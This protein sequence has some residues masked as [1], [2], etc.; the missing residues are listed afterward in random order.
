MDV[1]KEELK[2]LDIQHY[3]EDFQCSIDYS[4]NLLIYTP[5]FLIALIVYPINPFLAAL[6]TFLTTLCMVLEFKGVEIISTF[7]PKKDCLNSLYIYNPKP[8]QSL[9]I[10]LITA[11]KE[12]LEPFFNFTSVTGFRKKSKIII[13]SILAFNCV[14]FWGAFKSSAMNTVEVIYFWIALPLLVILYLALLAIYFKYRFSKINKFSS[15]YESLTATETFSELIS[16]GDIKNIQLWFLAREGDNGYDEGLD[17]FLQSCP[18]IEIAINFQSLMGEPIKVITEEG[19]LSTA[20]TYKPLILEAYNIHRIIFGTE[21]INGRYNG[22][23]GGYKLYQYGGIKTIT[24]SGKDVSFFKNK[25]L[26][27]LAIDNYKV[28]T[29]Q[30]IKNLDK[31]YKNL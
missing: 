31:F 17:L 9:P 26:D 3:E 13:F 29:R 28:F 15:G 1:I 8:Q 18:E 5:I 23:T 25:P 12:H 14:I 2:K 19:L 4:W 16:S 30:L 6:F 22:M 11:Q 7:L 27:E 21:L 10:I 24:I 20:K